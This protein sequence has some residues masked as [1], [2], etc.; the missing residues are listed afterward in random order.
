MRNV[1]DFPF[2]LI[3]HS[4]RPRSFDNRAEGVT[5]IRPVFFQ[6]RAPYSH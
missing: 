4:S 5:D 6:V 1:D 3:L 2:P